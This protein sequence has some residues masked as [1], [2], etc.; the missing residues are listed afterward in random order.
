MGISS[1]LASAVQRLQA[2]QAIRSQIR[3]A[4]P[5]AIER[6]AFLLDLVAEDESASENAKPTSAHAPPKPDRSRRARA[7]AAKK[8]SGRQK[9]RTPHHDRDDGR[10][11]KLF[12]L[13]AK[14]RGAP[15]GDLT[16]QIYGDAAKGSQANLRSLLVALK[17][18]G[19][20]N[21]Y[22]RG[23]WEVVQKQ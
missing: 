9:T 4:F 21:N 8:V 23:K 2:K 14:T 13:L 1:D 15:I 20:V 11:D 22:E 12:A 6:R 7:R 17:A 16:K 18:Q 19:R 3:S 5:D 10:T